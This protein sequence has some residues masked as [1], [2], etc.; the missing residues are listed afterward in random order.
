MKKYLRIP[1]EDRFVA[2]VASAA[3]PTDTFA[4]LLEIG[5]IAARDTALVR[6]IREAL[7]A[8]C[9]SMSESYSSLPE[10]AQDVYIVISDVLAALELPDYQAYLAFRLRGSPTDPQAGETLLH[11]LAVIRGAW[12][13]SKHRPWG[14]RPDDHTLRVLRAMFVSIFG[15]GKLPALVQTF[16]TDMPEAHLLADEAG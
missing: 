1:N 4:L 9:R 8:G 10:P 11:A 13:P 5:T 2:A 16:V 3:E 12:Y 7:E 15:T 6:Q 14:E